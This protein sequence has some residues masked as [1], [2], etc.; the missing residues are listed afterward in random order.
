MFLEGAVSEVK[1]FNKLKVKNENTSKKVIGV[2][3]IGK[4]LNG[5]L[6][7]SQTK[8]IINI[9]T[10]QY[11]KRQKTWAKG[12]MISWQKIEPKKLGLSLKNIK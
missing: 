2:E 5:E 11:A 10:R 12:Q 8:E 6:N 7:L 3:E 9:K 4:Y 1:K